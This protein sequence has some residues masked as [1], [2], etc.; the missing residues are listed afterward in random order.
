MIKNLTKPFA[1]DSLAVR[2][3]ECNSMNPSLWVR[4]RVSSSVSPITWVQFCESSSVSQSV[5]QSLW[6]GHRESGSLSPV[7]WVQFCESNSM[8]LVLW[9]DFRESDSVSQ[10]LWVSLPVGFCESVSLSPI[11]W[12]QFLKFVSV[13]SGFVS[14]AQWDHHCETTTVSPALWVQVCESGFESN[15]HFRDLPPSHFVPNVIAAWLNWLSNRWEGSTE[16]QSVFNGSLERR[17]L[18]AAVRSVQNA[19]MQ[20]PSKYVG[21]WWHQYVPLEH[22]WWLCN[23]YEDK[24]KM[25]QYLT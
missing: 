19:E 9:V 1:S 21:I 12:A 17:T 20:S 16:K 4:L 13:E 5:S 11:L 22:I 8:S 25:V 18:S 23:R 24:P 15:V 3:C 6:V 2:L 10:V 14:P 7:S